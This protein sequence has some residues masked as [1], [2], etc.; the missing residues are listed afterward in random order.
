MLLPLLLRSRRLGFTGRRREADRLFREPAF[1]S[2]F[3]DCF[4]L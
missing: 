3:L 1:E 2:S 4:T